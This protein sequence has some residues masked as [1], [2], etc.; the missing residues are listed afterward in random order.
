LISCTQGEQQVKHFQACLKPLGAMVS[1]LC[2]LFS[3]GCSAEFFVDKGHVDAIRGVEFAIQTPYLYEK[4]AFNL[5]AENLSAWQLQQIADAMPMIAAFTNA[6]L[7][8][9]TRT[10]VAAK[11]D[12]KVRSIRQ[13]QHIDPKTFLAVKTLQNWQVTEGQIQFTTD[14]FYT[15][16]DGHFVYFRDNYVFQKIQQ[17]W[18]FERHAQAQAEGLLRCEK[19]QHGWRQCEPR[20]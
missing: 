6:V 20:V 18:V 15:G 4:K 7:A 16:P 10:L 19:P 13:L 8:N 12:G 2:L 17:Q 5:R 1:W 11:R 3:A 9:D 14:Y